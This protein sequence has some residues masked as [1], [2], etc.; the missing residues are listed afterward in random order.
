LQQTSQEIAAARQIAVEE[1]AVSAVEKK[2]ER[3]QRKLL[4]NCPVIEVVIEPE[5]IDLEKYKRIGE[6]CT[7]TLEFEP[8]RLYVK[9]VIRLKY[10]LRGNTALPDVGK[11]SVVIAPLPLLPVYKGLLGA[12]LL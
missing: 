6:E 12:T 8:G 1:I 4:K 5:S 10:G 9:E 2:K 3:R 11:S 7:C